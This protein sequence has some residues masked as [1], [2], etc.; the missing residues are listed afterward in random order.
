M[1]Y[2][3]R[4]DRASAIEKLHAGLRI[5][6]SNVRINKILDDIGR[7]KPPPI[8]FLSRSNPLNIWFGKRRKNPSK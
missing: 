3:E 7:R 8:T 5:Q 1:V 4:N 6:P 2:L